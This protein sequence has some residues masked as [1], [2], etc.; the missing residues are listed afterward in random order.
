MGRD[1]VISAAASWVDGTALIESAQSSLMWSITCRFED[2]AMNYVTVYPTF[3][4]P[5]LLLS[6]QLQV[7][8]Y[9][10]DSLGQLGDSLMFDLVAR[11]R[12]SGSHM[13]H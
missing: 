2:C 13:A 11:P 12:T 8:E 10:A 5:R 9:I 4:N 3:H 1:Q 7:V 6:T